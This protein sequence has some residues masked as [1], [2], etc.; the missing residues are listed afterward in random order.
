MRAPPVLCSIARIVTVAAALAALVGTARVTCAQ[1]P[2]PPA[3]PVTV[4]VVDSTQVQV[5]KLRDGSSIVGRVT[6]VTA[7]TIRFMALMG[8][9]TIARRRRGAAGSREVRA[10]AR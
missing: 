4:R 5:I 10:A 9:L 6:E 7:D 2:T 3:K 1:Q 8:T